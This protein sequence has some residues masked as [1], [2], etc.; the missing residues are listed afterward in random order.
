MLAIDLC[1]C[2]PLFPPPYVQDE[3]YEAKNKAL[4][5]LSNGGEAQSGLFQISRIDQVSSTREGEGDE[6]RG[7]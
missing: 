2:F 3:R 7:D 4:L 6:L 5:T 1:A